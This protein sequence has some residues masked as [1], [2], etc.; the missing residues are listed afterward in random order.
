V[1]YDGYNYTTVQ[2]GSQCWFKEDL[3]NDNY[4]DGS[5]ITGNLDDA[6]WV[7]TS[8]GAQAVYGE[9]SSAVTRGNG[10]EVANLATYGRIYNWYA[11][12]TGLLCPSGWHVPTYAEW[13]TLASTLGGS[14]VAGTKL[15]VS[16][17]NTPAWDGDNASGFS[18]LPA[19]WRDL[20]GYF[21]GQNYDGSWW[22]SY[23]PDN[24]NGWYYYLIS[25]DAAVY[26]YS[27]STRYGFS[28][29]CL[30]D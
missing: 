11:V 7:G 27:G 13:D 26:R 14:S 4:N 12:S 6:S 9:G 8:S 15:K 22:S 20:T 25:A 10:D 19:G 2:I 1:S 5:A 16:P 29:R 17:S 23:S 18:A 24:S 28:V 3:R 21:D 30:Q